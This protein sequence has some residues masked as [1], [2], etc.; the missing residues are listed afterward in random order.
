[1]FRTK[2]NKTFRLPMSQS[3]YTYVRTD[4]G[5]HCPSTLYVPGTKMAMSGGSYMLH[6]F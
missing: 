1:M 3:G 6:V 2:Y 4:Q 5:T